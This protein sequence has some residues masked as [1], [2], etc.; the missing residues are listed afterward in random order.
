MLGLGTS[1]LISL[2]LDFVSDIV[3]V[4]EFFVTD[5]QRCCDQRRFTVGGRI[6]SDDHDMSQVPPM[7]RLV[8]H[9]PRLVFGV[10]LPGSKA[11][12]CMA[13]VNTPGV[14]LKPHAAR[15]VISVDP[16]VEQALTNIPGATVEYMALQGT[17][18]ATAS[19]V[20]SSAPVVTPEVAGLQPRHL[21]EGNLSQRWTQS[22][23]F[24]LRHRWF[25]RPGG[26]TAQQQ[27]SHVL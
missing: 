5:L 23:N 11:V 26:A 15:P 7:L 10:L 1:H 22:M 9:G 17:P 12:Q 24:Y 13:G 21:W 6:T 27:T 25:R 20:C 14:Q 2:S 18:A 8:E 16:G 19:P 3:E 4:G